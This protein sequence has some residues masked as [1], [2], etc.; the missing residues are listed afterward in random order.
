METIDVVV[1]NKTVEAERVAAF[2]LARADRAALPPFTAGAH[3]DVHLPGQLVRQYSLCGSTQDL[4]RYTIAVLR[5]PGSRGGSE[6]IHAAVREGDVLRIGAPRNHFP[7]Q[8][9]P[10]YVLLAGGIGITPMICMAD[11]LARQGA[12]FE[13]HYCSRS[14]Q[15]AAF[16]GRLAA[17]PYAGHVHCH[18]DDG[19]PQQRLDLARV[20]GDAGMDSHVYVCG[21]GGFINHVEGG[22]A[23]AGLAAQQ[24]HREYFS[25]APLD[26]TGDKAFE[27]TLARSG[28][29]LPVPAGRSVLEVLLAHGVD[30]PVSCEQGVCGTCVT[31]V[32]EGIPHHRDMYFTDQEHASN[33]QFTPCCSR[34]KTP[35][36]VLDL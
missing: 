22:A 4:S 15:L 14:P 20:F 36:L 35:S 32:L 21:P 8:P 29:R 17:A 27:I 18:Y 28:R 6:A 19:A 33:Q 5:E 16:R 23:L 7:L 24:V 9:A 3:I 25:A 31:R 26:T 13:L 1:V 30:I 34:S 2:E 12:R 10:Y 11:E